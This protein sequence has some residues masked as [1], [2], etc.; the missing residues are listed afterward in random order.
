MRSI[1]RSGALVDAW[2]DS[3]ASDLHRD[4]AR[5]LREVVMAAEPKLVPGLQWGNLM[6]T[7]ERVH[8]VA[9]VPH[10]AHVNLQFFNGALLAERYPQLDGTQ[11]GTRLLKCGLRQP[12]D[13]ALVTELV[14]ACVAALAT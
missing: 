13:E 10:R 14:K 1:L 8:A 12:V 11:R 4:L 9:I 3:L 7:H 2:F 5:R 6:F